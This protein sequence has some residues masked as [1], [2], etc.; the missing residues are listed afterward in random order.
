MFGKRLRAAGYFGNKESF[1]WAH[2]TGDITTYYSTTEIKELIEAA[3]KVT[4]RSIAQT[5]TLTTIKNSIGFDVEKEK[6]R[7]RVRPEV[8]LTLLFIWRAK[9]DGI[10]HW[11]LGI[12]LPIK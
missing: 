5:P 10:G 1:A 2:H 6:K 7:K 12:E 11:S 4:D 3:E 9:A 8:G